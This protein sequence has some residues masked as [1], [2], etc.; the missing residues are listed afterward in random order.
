[1]K[2]GILAVLS[3]VCMIIFIVLMVSF[4]NDRKDNCIENGGKVVTDVYGLFDKCV[5]GDD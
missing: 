3:F 1:M 2:D 4:L 5:Y